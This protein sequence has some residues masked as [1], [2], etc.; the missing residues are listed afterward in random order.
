MRGKNFELY[1]SVTIPLRLGLP[2]YHRPGP[3]LECCAMAV[4]AK[5]E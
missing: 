2:K 4:S 1:Y 3:P 5:L